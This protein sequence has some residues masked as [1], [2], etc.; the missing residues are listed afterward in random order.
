MHYMQPGY[1]SL[2]VYIHLALGCSM[3]IGE[4]SGLQWLK[5]SLDAENDACFENAEN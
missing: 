3:R 5:V 1:N 2:L 4:I